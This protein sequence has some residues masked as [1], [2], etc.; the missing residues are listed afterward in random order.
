MP[1]SAWSLIDLTTLPTTPGTELSLEQDG[2]L[3]RR[4]VLPGG[5]RV[6]TEQIPGSRSATVGA[7][8]AAGSRDE[9][10]EHAGS[11]HFLEHLLFK[12]TPKRTAYD[13]S[14]AFD[15][16]GGDAN[17]ATAKN[18]TCYYAR[19]I[20]ADLPMAVEVLLDMVTSSSI[21]EADFELER[22]VI[23]EE[24]AMSLDDPS[25]LV[26]ERFTETVL[27]GHPLG[28]PI[29]G[30]PESIASLPHSA[31]LEH[32]SRTYVPPE[33]VVTAAGNVRHEDVV[34]AVL[35]GARRGGWDLPDDGEPAPRRRAGDVSYAPGRSVFL[36]RPV[37]QAHLILGWPGLANSDPRRFALGVANTLLGGGMSSR[38]F[39]EIRERR[40][41]AY[42]TYSFSSMYAEGGVYGMYAATSPSVARQVAD[43]MRAEA[44]RLVAEPVPAAELARAIGQIR[45]NFVL[46]LEDSGARMTRLGAAEIVTGRLLSFDETL[47]N[48]FSVTVEEIQQVAADVMGGV[49]ALVVVG[50]AAAGAALT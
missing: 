12:G 39:Q 40:G 22:G 7:W 8:V 43:L 48:Y 26:H 35:D 37:E 11:T 41:L 32:Y 23:L 34:S 29:G 17:A 27:A 16:V 21:T 42:S 44:E 50:A 30:T 15:A 3:V 13:I 2:A 46:S 6:L 14:S 18:Y 28:R 10:E 19:V 49:P 24:L 31:V 47:R 5:I 1:E 36:E 45:G 20:D 4:S 9:R 33:L 38:L 25:D